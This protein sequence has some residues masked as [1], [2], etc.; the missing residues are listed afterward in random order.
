VQLTGEDDPPNAI[1]LDK[2]LKH[3]ALG[4][5]TSMIV[6]GSFRDP[7]VTLNAVTSAF[8]AGLLRQ[9]HVGPAY[10]VLAALVPDAIDEPDSKLQGAHVNGLVSGSDLLAPR[11]G[12]GPT[13]DPEQARTMLRNRYD[14][15][16]PM[17]RYTLSRVI[18]DPQAMAVVADLRTEGWKD[19]HLLTGLLNL[20]LNH[21]LPQISDPRML[22]VPNMGPE[23]PNAV[24]LPLDQI[25]C[26]ALDQGRRAALLPLGRHWGLD[27]HQTT[28]DLG[29]LERLLAARYGYWDEDVEHADPF[30]L[31][32][33]T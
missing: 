31:S 4:H 26:K 14:N 27:L 30:S 25:T 1:S 29:G 22:R 17:L 16:P 21:R 5:A 24:P 6:E 12:P 23:D 28:P 8:A 11:S 18:A 9:L 15:I 20:V 7:D 2:T 33:K 10:D 19:W 3:E 32:V 13:Y